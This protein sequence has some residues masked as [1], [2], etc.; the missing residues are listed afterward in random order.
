MAK[1]DLRQVSCPDDRTIL[2]FRG[3]ELSGEEY[4]AVALHLLFCNDCVESLH[5]LPW[6]EPEDDEG[7]S[8]EGESEPQ[9]HVTP[10]LSRAIRLFRER[11]EK[12]A[13]GTSGTTK[14]I[15]EGDLRAGQIWRTKSEGIVVPTLGGAGYHSVTELN[16]RPHLVVV[17]RTEV[18]GHHFGTDYHRLL[19]VPLDGDTEY[20]GE[21]DLFVAQE[22][23]P[24]GYS[25]I[26]QLW[27]EQ[28][29]LRENLDCCLG[30]L[31]RE[32]HEG[33]MKGLDRDADEESSGTDYSLEAVIMRGLY[34]DPV[35][36]YRAKEYEDTA[37]LRMPAQSLRDTIVKPAAGLPKATPIVRLAAGIDVEEEGLDISDQSPVVQARVMI[38]GRPFEFAEDP[39]EGSVFLLGDIPPGAT[40]VQIGPSS[41]EL[42]LSEG[43]RSA[44]VL[45]AGLA[46]LEMPL[47][48]H[49]ADPANYPIRFAS[50]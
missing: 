17:T 42:E 16:S 30:E 43:R 8:E 41:Y 27:N 11:H 38:N 9:A 14:E 32:Q 35:M 40:R 33:L 47:K 13:S 49:F 25:F 39:T 4:D 31:S 46:D 50:R 23:S 19:V 12:N 6:D 3:N 18:G 45:G 36:R 48:R 26:A 2:A 44:E 21:G 34:Q 20:R 1:K 29:M 24:L 37:Y 5:T 15:E 28:P 10:S 22:D 7:V